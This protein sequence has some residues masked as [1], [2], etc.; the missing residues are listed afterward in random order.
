ME[1]R[2]QIIPPG[3]YS[4]DDLK[5]YGKERNWCPYFLARFTVRNFINL[6]LCTH[7]LNCVIINTLWIFRFY[8]HKL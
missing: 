3:I 6:F 1:G 7:D 8:M 5:D 4:I 2:E